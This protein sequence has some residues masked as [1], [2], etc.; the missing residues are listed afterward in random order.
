MG[1]FFK[2]FPFSLPA[3]RAPGDGWLARESRRGSRK[4]RQNQY[5]RLDDG[6]PTRGRSGQDLLVGDPSLHLLIDGLN[7]FKKNVKIIS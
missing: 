6:R 4:K 5:G 1:G 7:G 3:F 2:A